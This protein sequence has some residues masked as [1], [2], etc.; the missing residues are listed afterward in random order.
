[1]SLVFVLMVAIGALM[2]QPQPLPVRFLYV[3][4]EQAAR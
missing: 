1:M 2:N 3:R 4:N